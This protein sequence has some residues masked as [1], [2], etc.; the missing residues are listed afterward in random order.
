MSHELGHLM[1]DLPDLYDTKDDVT[2]EGIGE[3]G[4]M[5]TGIWNSVGTYI[6]ETPS[7]LS[8]WSK[9]AT[10]FTIPQDIDFDEAAVSIAQAETIEDT[11][12]LWVDRY[13]SD[14]SQEYFL[15]E[16]RQQTG[17]D[18]GLPGEGLLIWH[19]DE[20]QVSNEDENHK[21]VDLEEADGL[22]DLDNQSNRGDGAD[23]FP[24]TL[25]NFTFDNASNPNSKNYAGANTGIAVTSISA[26]GA[27]MTANFTSLAGGVGDHVRYDESGSLSSASLGSTTAWLGIRALNDTSYSMFDGVDVYVNDTVGATIDIYYYDSMAGGAPVGLIHSETGI[28]TGPN[29]VRLLLATPQPFPVGAERGIVIKVV[30]A[31]SEGPVVYDSVGAAS[32]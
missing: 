19:I 24:G 26:P 1:L 13:K 4:L 5:G 10:N 18:A 2:S 22:N 9:V 25:P 31:G 3:W 32:G 23:S 11:K 29:W 16:N 30:N 27:V 21:R 20:G 6:G 12:R 14:L 17:Y 15:V 7:H 28:A 8:A